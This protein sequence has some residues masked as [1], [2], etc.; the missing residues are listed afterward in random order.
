MKEKDLS[1]LHLHLGSFIRNEF[2]LW[3][4]N[5]ELMESCQYI[6]GEEDLHDDDASKLIIEELWKR[7]QKMPDLKMVK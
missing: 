6:S 7:L 5:N 3:S 4:E 1:T 2:G